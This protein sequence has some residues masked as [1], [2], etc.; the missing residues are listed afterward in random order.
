MPSPGERHLQ[1]SCTASA[2]ARH[3]PPF[4]AS[5]SS[6]KAGTLAGRS[7]RGT[8][9]G[10][11]GGTGGAPGETAGGRAGKRCK[12]MLKEQPL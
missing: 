5:L 1:P 7:G 3:L 6:N 4:L 12:W 8:G 10:G 2:A 11:E 9:S